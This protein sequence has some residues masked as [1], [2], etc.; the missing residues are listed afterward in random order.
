MTPPDTYQ[1]ESIMKPLF[2]IILIASGMT[3][4]VK[5]QGFAQRGR[6]PGVP[7]V[8]ILMAL[9]ANQ[10]GKISAAEIKNA[11]AA[12]KTLDK[13]GDGKLTSEKMGWPPNFGRGGRGGPG[14]GGRGGSSR[15]QRPNPEIGN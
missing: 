9:D 7:P 5:G 6:G 3:T 4:F 13:N 12:L 2:L 15:P 1:S 8:A 14:R 11:T 10:D